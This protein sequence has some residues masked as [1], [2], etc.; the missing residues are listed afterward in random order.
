MAQGLGSE[1]EQ[2]PKPALP[3]S[4][5][6]LL[7]ASGLFGVKHGFNTF[8]SFKARGPQSCLAVTV[9]PEGFALCSY[10]CSD[11]DD[12]CCVYHIGRRIKI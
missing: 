12:V 5:C 9:F 1:T 4:G 2:E 8:P 11:Y 3:G 7:T 6:G 10:M